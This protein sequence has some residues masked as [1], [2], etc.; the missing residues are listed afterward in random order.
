MSNDY[1]GLETHITFTGREAA[2]LR[3]ALMAYT[4]FTDDDDELMVMENIARKM[5]T[6]VRFANESN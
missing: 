3:K 4:E 6:G 2:V 1:P 5:L